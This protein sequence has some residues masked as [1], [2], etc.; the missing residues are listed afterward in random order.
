MPSLIDRLTEIR[1]QFESQFKE[2]I[3]LQPTSL[4][5]PVRHVIAAGGKRVRPLLTALSYRLG[6]GD[7]GWLE[8][9]NAIELLHTFTLV[10]DDIMD[11]AASRRGLTTVHE[12]FGVNAAILSGD[13]LIALAQRSLAKSSNA[14]ALLAEFATGFIRVCEG[15]ALDKDYEM[16]DDLEI[17][18]Y[19]HMIDLKTAKIAETA[20]VLGVLAS[21]ATENVE[22][23]RSFAHH[24]GMAFQIQDD[25]LD[26]TAEHA[27]LGKT[28]GGD[29]LEGKRTY[30]LLKLIDRAGDL[31]KREHDSLVNV[32]ERRATTSDIPTIRTA[33]I[34]TGVVDETIDAVEEQTKLALA[35]LDQVKGDTS[36]LREFADWL[37]KRKH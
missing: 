6:S 4:Y 30:L 19:L 23:I 17:A 15:Q 27:D 10:H 28:I 25:L 21:G 33:A 26:L 34:R 22:A 11:R 1:D 29:I 16:R 2:L 3:P 14:E 8:A 32:L 12:Q 13:V 31:E 36:D 24:T 37:L 9:A 35:A 20:A 5:D 7:D 18:D